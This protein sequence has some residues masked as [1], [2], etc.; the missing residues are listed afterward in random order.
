MA[1][2]DVT[3]NLSRDLARPRSQKVMQL[4]ERIPLIVCD[5]PAKFG[6]HMHYV[7]GDMFLIFLDRTELKIAWKKITTFFK[8]R[9]SIILSSFSS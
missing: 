2:G 7:G 5:H 9:V 6:G 8:P 4:Y 1:Y 3:F